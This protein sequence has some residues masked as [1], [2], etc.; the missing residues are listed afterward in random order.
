MS[1]SQVWIVVGERSISAAMALIDPPAFLA[2]AT[3]ARSSSRA[4]SSPATA[5]RRRS[6]SLGGM[7]PLSVT[8][9]LYQPLTHC[10]N[11]CYSDGMSNSGSAGAVTNVRVGN[12]S[13]IH[14]GFY[15]QDRDRTV[16]WCGAE[17]VGANLLGPRRTSSIT[18]TSE[19][20][21]CKRCLRMST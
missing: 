21:T 5:L 6:R 13:A 9:T 20:V 10:N 17:A 7:S 15:Q 19:P 16:P 12:G 2:A 18:T 11:H 3:A 14:R 4:L 8:N 1:R